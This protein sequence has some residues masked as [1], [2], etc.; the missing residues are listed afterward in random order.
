MCRSSEG[1]VAGLVR[2]QRRVGQEDA[3]SLLTV[4]RFAHR[5]HRT[6]VAARGRNLLAKS[7]G[8]MPSLRDLRVGRDGGTPLNLVR[9]EPTRAPV[10]A[11]LLG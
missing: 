9:A 1:N 6:A 11:S 3:A 2:L 4:L 8:S 7:P 10:A 5:R